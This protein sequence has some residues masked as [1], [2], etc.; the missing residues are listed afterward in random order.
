M[1]WNSKQPFLFPLSL[2]FPI[3][4]RAIKGNQEGGERH[5]FH[6]VRV[7]EACDQVHVEG[8]IGR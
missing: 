4:Y 2:G 7:K 8:M 1:H 5:F 6:D 3:T